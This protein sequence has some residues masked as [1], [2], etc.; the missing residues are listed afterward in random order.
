M[1]KRLHFSSALA[2]LLFVSMLFTVRTAK[3]QDN[4]P[5]P[6]P[7]VLT[8][9]SNG[10]ESFSP[11]ENLSRSGAASQPRIV[12]STDGILQAFWIDKFDGLMSSI[13]I[14][15]TWSVPIYSA[16]QPFLRF[17]DARPMS[18]MPFFIEDSFGRVHAFFYGDEDIYTGIRPLLH[19]QTLIGS[20][21]WSLPQVIAE[22]AV[23]FDVD[24][25]PEGDINIAYIRTLN[26][27][28]APSGL[29]F[30]RYPAE[31]TG[32]SAPS[33]V[34]PS[35]YYRLFTK[36][37][38]WV[39]ISDGGTGIVH[40]VWQDPF[41]GISYYNKTIDSGISWS[42]PEAIGDLSEGAFHPRI[43]SALTTNLRNWESSPELCSLFQQI[44]SVENLESSTQQLF[45]WSDPLQIFP[46]LD[47]CPVGDKFYASPSDNSILWIWGQGTQIL[48][49]SQWSSEQKSWTDVKDLS[50]IFNESENE[51]QIVLD[52]L[53][54][55]F[56]GEKLSVVG[57]DTIKGEIWSTELLVNLDDV[58]L[59]PPSPWIS[60]QSILSDDQTDID[61]AEISSPR[62]EMDS[63]GIAHIIW[64][65][66]SSLS[67]NGISINYSRWDGSTLTPPVELFTNAQNEGYH[68]YD[69]FTDLENNL[70]T[71]WVSGLEGG[72][73][74][75]KAAS[76]SAGTPSG[77][78]PEQK[79]T[80]IGPTSSPKLGMGVNGELYLFYTIPVN[81][82]RGVYFTLSTDKGST[83]SPP[84]QIVDG[85]MAGWE[86]IDRPTFLISSG[87]TI[88]VAGVYGPLA[89]SGFP[90]GI[91]YTRSIEGGQTWTDPISLTEA[92]FDYPRLVMINDQLHVFYVNISDNSLYHRYVEILPDTN[93]ESA[94]YSPIQIPG[95]NNISAPYGLFGTKIPGLYGS[96]DSE[97]HLLAI[98]LV[99]G[100]LIYNTWN[101]N[102][103]SQNEI[104]DLSYALEGFQFQPGMA[105]STSADI[106]SA[107]QG[108]SLGVVWRVLGLE[109]DQGDRNL[110]PRLFYI[111]REIDPV[112]I[113]YLPQPVNKPTIVSPT[114]D[115]ISEPTVVIS[116]TPQI[117]DPVQE[118]EAPVR[119]FSPLILGGGLAVVIIILLFL[120]RWYWNKRN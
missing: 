10:Q 37:N 28:V 98:D 93:A 118:D 99:S 22:S 104:V 47:N 100:N 3:A 87:G 116:P 88:H 109:Q 4:T 71:A 91:F 12:S 65:Q 17:N 105:T 58:T 83:W 95:W 80:E 16:I 1:I 62:V 42:E 108:G 73:I 27:E 66:T 106:T 103:W 13:N 63:N 96:T 69:L 23:E 19:S 31:S 78:L 55:T 26:T 59:A 74:Y 70:H 119:T 112:E 102:N 114:P 68:Q 29:Y 14:E 8:G 56:N 20:V 45:S 111:E 34:Y 75:S 50:F 36:D 51:P 48:S 39:R 107:L 9:S 90:Q 35:I 33:L 84:T 32:W 43:F 97:I 49:I 15:G 18:E 67:P 110:L 7:P 81:E 5:F 30:K 52:D 6:T 61:A 25:S 2:A 89:E 94:W 77:W 21:Q 40:V 85:V 72:I 41:Q 92:G 11:P 79:L 115:I 117:A 54:V 76:D 44:N 101:G 38:A 24:T 46:G 64:S 82:D 53:H 86:V 60:M 57:T 120:W 113:N